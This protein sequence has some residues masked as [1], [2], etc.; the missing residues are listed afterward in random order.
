MGIAL[1]T[2]AGYNGS[3]K[4]IGQQLLSLGSVSSVTTA[5]STDPITRH[6]R[7]KDR[8]TRAVIVLLCG[9]AL[10]VSG[11]ALAFTSAGAELILAALVTVVTAALMRPTRGFLLVCLAVLFT[12]AGG[13]LMVIDAL[14][15]GL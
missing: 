5:M 2:T 10:G 3:T 15:S 12:I 1:D 7:E 11:W 8:H 13:P 14:V 4:P 6:R 9:L